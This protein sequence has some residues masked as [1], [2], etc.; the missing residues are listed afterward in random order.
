MGLFWSPK[1]GAFGEPKRGAFGPL[2]DTYLT[3]IWTHFGPFWRPSETPHFR[4]ILRPFGPFWSQEWLKIATFG[5]VLRPLLDPFLGCSQ[6]AKKG[7]K[8]VKKEVIL[9]PN[10]GD[11]RP[12]KQAQIWLILTYLEPRMAQNGSEW[13]ILRPDLAHFDVYLRGDPARPEHPNLHH[14]SSP[15]RPVANPRVESL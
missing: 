10:L 8:E 15:D 13:L 9:D 6:R 7:Q 11:S 1:R 5:P 3:H 2:L 4:P 14:P 12:S